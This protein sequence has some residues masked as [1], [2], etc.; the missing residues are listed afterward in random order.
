MSPSIVNESLCSK[1]TEADLLS[2]GFVRT[3]DGSGSP[4]GISYDYETSGYRIW[5]DCTYVVAL[6]RKNPD[7]DWVKVL[8]DDLADLD[9]LLAWVADDDGEQTTNAK[10]SA[11]GRR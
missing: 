5:I 6:S 2:R 10:R 3:D 9:N 7:T 8:I 1:A 4:F 11:K